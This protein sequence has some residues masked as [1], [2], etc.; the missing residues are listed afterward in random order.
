[1]RCGALDHVPSTMRNGILDENVNS[2]KW[3]SCAQ[4]RELSMRNGIV[5]E[6]LTLRNGRV[7]DT[8]QNDETH[9]SCSSGLLYGVAFMVL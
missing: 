3:H 5:N 4:N 8:S 1:M 2:A 7:N 6:N 9:A